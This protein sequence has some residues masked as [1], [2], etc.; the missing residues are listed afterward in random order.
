MRLK[1]RL[2]IAAVAPVH[3]QQLRHSQIRTQTQL[4]QEKVA[5]AEMESTQGNRASDSVAIEQ[6]R[7]TVD[8]LEAR[9][10]ELEQMRQADK[11][12]RKSL[13]EARSLDEPHKALTQKDVFQEDEVCEEEDHL[14]LLKGH[15]KI[16]VSHCQ[17]LA[18]LNTALQIDWPS[19]ITGFV[20]TL[21]VFSFDVYGIFG[22]SC[23][24]SMEPMRVV[25]GAA[26]GLCVLSVIAYY[27]LIKVLKRERRLAKNKVL[28]WLQLILFL[29][30][31]AVCLKALQ[32]FE[33]RH[34]EGEYYKSSDVTINCYNKG[35]ADDAIIAAATIL[36]FMLGYPI[37]VMVVLLRNRHKLWIFRLYGV[38][39][40]DE[41]A[42]E[43][44]H[45]H[46]NN[47][48]TTNARLSFFYHRYKPEYFLWEMSETLRKLL[49]TSLSIFVYPGEA[50]QV[51]FAV[52][53]SV[54]FLGLQASGEPYIRAS[55]NNL[56]LYCLVTV[57][58]TVTYG[59]VVFAEDEAHKGTQA[60][61]IDGGS[62]FLSWLV[63]AMN[64]FILVWFG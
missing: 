16:I 32:V 35:W 14:E 50:R 60:A 55:E 13:G 64:C 6:Q 23:T 37:L 38:N 59:L 49:M 20:E 17:V 31:P 5:L 12:A 33:C 26:V 10:D 30:W 28:K 44:F 25:V 4:K 46:W 39:V 40:H 57:T 27:F 41:R 45:P 1:L 42:A 48:N 15:V 62:K 21:G 19:E 2:V 36:I 24:S 58:V 52:L 3:A 9:V 47:W 53:V 43:L 63:I 29:A 22:V 34:I 7:V 51:A 18:A 8:Q 54:V 61:L 56:Q 11:E